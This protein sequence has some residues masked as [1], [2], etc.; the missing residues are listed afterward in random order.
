M[1]LEQF[2]AWLCGVEDMQEIDWTPSPSQ[3]KKIRDKLDEIDGGS[4]PT[5]NSVVYRPPQTNVPLF[6]PAPSLLP[7]VDPVSL[8]H[9]RFDSEISQP[10]V[11]SSNV[12]NTGSGYRSGFV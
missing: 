10:Q 7:R 1:T 8:P 5:T 12:P 9:V 11:D 2:R 6:E 4:Q 3:W